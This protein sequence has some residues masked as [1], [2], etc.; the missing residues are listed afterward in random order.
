MRLRPFEREDAECYRTWVNDEEIAGL[1]DRVRPV[2]RLEH[3]AWYEALVRSDRT[4]AFAVDRRDNERFIGLAWLHGVEWRHRRAEVRIVL[5]DRES[6]G[7]GYGTDALRVLVSIAF[8]PMGLEKLWAE[9]LATNGRAVAAFERAGFVREGVLRQD[10]IHTGGRVDVV[11][12]GIL[13]SIDMEPA[14]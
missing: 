12:L 11:R 7:K 5:G 4:C 6:W 9:A 14:L 2:T 1:V 8:G 3:E 13:R 10:R